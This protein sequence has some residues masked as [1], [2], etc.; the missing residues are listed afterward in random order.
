MRPMQEVVQIG[1]EAQQGS[2]PVWPLLNDAPE[3]RK[4]QS[5]FTATQVQARVSNN[6][7]TQF[8]SGAP[9]RH[10][11]T[12]DVCIGDSRLAETIAEPAADAGAIVAILLPNAR[13]ADQMA[14]EFAQWV[15][16]VSMA[17]VT[18]ETR[19]VQYIREITPITQRLQ[20]STA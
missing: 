15:P 14:R 17:V 4:V 6:V 1:G 9:C 5:P 16:D 2:A 10:L 18:G 8:A 20:P 19:G 7:A 12:G 13:L 3:R 11:I